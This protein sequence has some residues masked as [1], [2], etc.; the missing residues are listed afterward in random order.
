VESLFL[1]LRHS[2]HSNLCKMQAVESLFLK[3]RL[4]FHTNNQT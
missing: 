2:Y 4:L 3:L 1:K